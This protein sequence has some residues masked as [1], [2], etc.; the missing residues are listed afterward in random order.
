MKISVAIPTYKRPALLSRCLEAL[1]NQRFDKNNF[2]IIVV[3]DGADEQ[4][5]EVIDRF[6]NIELPRLS[7]YVLSEH[8]GPAAARNVGWHHAESKLIAFTDDDCIPEPQWLRK[9][10]NAYL[11]VSKSK[12]A[13]TGHTIVP[14][15]AD[16]TDYER[17]VANLEKAEFITANCACTRHALIKA[18]GFDEAFSMAWREDSDL[19]FKFIHHGI[20]IIPVEAKVT[21]PVRKAHWGISLKEERKGMFDALLYKKFPRLYRQ[22]IQTSPPWRYYA[23]IACFITCLIGLFSKVPWLAATGFAGW[24]MLEV[25]FIYRRLSSTRKTFDHISEMIVTSLVI[26]FLSIY[27]RLYGIIKYRTSLF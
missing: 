26:P 19:Q 22:K 2:E 1:Y 11:R 4:T 6:R 15:P 27:W 25:A 18:G 7:Y 14:I 9:F 23:M 8:K 24:I 17:N 13:F 16:P 5:K 3:S 12:V 10:Y 21:H 20:P